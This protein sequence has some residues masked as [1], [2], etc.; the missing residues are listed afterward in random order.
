MNYL[1]K[2]LMQFD[3]K[4]KKISFNRIDYNIPI[5]FSV[6]NFTMALE[7]LR[8]AYEML[9]CLFIIKLAS[10]NISSSKFKF[11]LSCDGLRAFIDFDDIHCAFGG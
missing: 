5:F 8:K 2:L 4:M 9:L 10:I 11:K 1:I 3:L 6:G 7:N